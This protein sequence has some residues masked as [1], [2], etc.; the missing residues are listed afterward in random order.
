M[1]LCR[2][3][4][5]FSGARD[6][7]AAIYNY[8]ATTYREGAF[9]PFEGPVLAGQQCLEFR[10][11]YFTRGKTDLYP[12]A[13]ID[14]TIDPFGILQ[15]TLENKRLRYTVEN[16]VVYRRRTDVHEDGQ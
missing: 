5:G 12:A 6:A 15:K 1:L 10:T 2:G 16:R 8:M 4:P 13:E 7:L 3:V 11:R 14:P 9:L